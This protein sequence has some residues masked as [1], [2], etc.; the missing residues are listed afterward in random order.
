MIRGHPL[1]G[2]RSRKKRLPLQENRFLAEVG[3]C[4]RRGGAG[5]LQSFGWIV[6]NVRS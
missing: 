4:R 6:S 2:P 3:M 1:K 5:L